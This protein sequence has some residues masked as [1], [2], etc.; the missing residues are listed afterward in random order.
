MPDKIIARKVG[1]KLKLARE[2]AGLRQKDLAKKINRHTSYISHLETGKAGYSINTLQQFVEPLRLKDISYFFQW[3]QPITKISDGSTSYGV[4]NDKTINEI[5]D[6]L[7]EHPD[8][9]Q[10][11][12]EYLL[13]YYEG[14]KGHLS[15]LGGII[16]ALDPGQIEE[17]IPILCRR[18]KESK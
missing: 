13:S 12:K 7:R 11:V 17:L 14:G 15:R 10:K 18:L 8:A 4:E 9:Q 5:T 3:D 16:D 6:I 2:K 1:N